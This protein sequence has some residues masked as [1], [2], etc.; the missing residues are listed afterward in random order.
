MGTVS[1]SFQLGWQA[2]FSFTGTTCGYPDG[3]VAA[4]STFRC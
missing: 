2:G 3:V 1:F 4:A